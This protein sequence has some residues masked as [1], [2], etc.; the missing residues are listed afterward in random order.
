MHSRTLC[1]VSLQRALKK[2]NAIVKL[3]YNSSAKGGGGCYNSCTSAIHNGPHIL[4]SSKSG[5]K[6]IRPFSTVKPH[7]WFKKPLKILYKLAGWQSIASPWWYLSC[8]KLTTIHV[9]LCTVRFSWIAFGTLA[10]GCV[11]CQTPKA[12]GTRAW[13]FQHTWWN[14]ILQIDLRLV[15]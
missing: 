5:W 12:S 4:C 10:W 3:N 1:T 15:R 2:Q 9:R 11:Y 6:W 14:H 13:F 8:A 7:G